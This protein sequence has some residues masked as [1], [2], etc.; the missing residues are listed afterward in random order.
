MSHESVSVIMC[1]GVSLASRTEDA[2]KVTL[3]ARL[4]VQGLDA[5]C[6]AALWWPGLTASPSA[7]S[8]CRCTG[9]VHRRMGSRRNAGDRQRVLV[10]SARGRIPLDPPKKRDGGVSRRGSARLCYSQE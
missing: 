5:I 6:S 9:V 3:L 2:A 8:C 10:R 1:D 4:D 7:Q